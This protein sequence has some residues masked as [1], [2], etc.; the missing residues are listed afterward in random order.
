MALYG[1]LV[2]DGKRVFINKLDAALASLKD[3]EC[4]AAVRQEDVAWI[5]T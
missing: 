2:L 1:G 4:V 5:R 3:C